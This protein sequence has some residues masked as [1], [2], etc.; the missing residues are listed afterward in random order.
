MWAGCLSGRRERFNPQR[1]RVILQVVD[2]CTSVERHAPEAADGFLHFL[3][4][5]HL[6]AHLVESTARRSE[7]DEG[8]SYRLVV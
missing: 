5:A 1:G 7:L 4:C 8:R 2:A 6:D 3:G